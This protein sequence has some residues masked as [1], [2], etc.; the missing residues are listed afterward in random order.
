MR[1][2]HTG[3][4]TAR[5]AFS[6]SPMAK[7]QLPILV[8]SRTNAAITV[9]MIQK[10]I[11]ILMLTGPIENDAPKIAFAESKPAMSLMSLLATPPV[12]ARVRPR[13][14]PWRTKN[15]ARVMRKLGNPLRLSMKP[16]IAPIASAMRRLSPTAAHT[17]KLKYQASS[18][19]D[20]PAV[21][22][23]TPAERSNS[24]ATMSSATGTAMMP[25]VAAW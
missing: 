14:T 2:F 1:T 15:V 5:A 10:M 25:M 19:A 18:D 6:S 9:R 22:T 8:R 20:I 12:T 3:T 16:L 23:A 21:V 24:P 7:I 17:W 4:P 13:F 11:G